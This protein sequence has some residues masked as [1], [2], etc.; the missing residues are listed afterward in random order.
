[1]NVRC[2]DPGTVVGGRVRRFDG[3][4]GE[5]A[6]AALPR[7]EEAEGEAA[8]PRVAGMESRS[9]GSERGRGTGSAPEARDPER[10]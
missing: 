8:T 10:S 3:A 9:V 7:L 1:M 5:R 2:L 6:A 4:H